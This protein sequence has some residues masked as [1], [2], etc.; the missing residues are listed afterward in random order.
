MEDEL[1]TRYEVW[2]RLPVSRINAYERD[3]ASAQLGDFLSVHRPVSC[4]PA[5]V[6]RRNGAAL[7]ETRLIAAPPQPAAGCVAG[8]MRA[9]AAQWAPVAALEHGALLVTY[10]D[11]AALVR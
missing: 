2:G 4:P 7:A 3:A 10:V 8:D 5:R 11:V 9:V 6:R 1:G